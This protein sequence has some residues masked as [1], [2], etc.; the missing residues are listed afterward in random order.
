MAYLD[1]VD[2][3]NDLTNRHAVVAEHQLGGSTLK[4]LTERGWEDYL[5]AAGYSAVRAGRPLCTR[6]WPPTMSAPCPA[7]CKPS[8]PASARPDRTRPWR[9]CL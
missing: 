7:P 9:S 1:T 4:V 2:H 3:L 8:S 5:R 6:C